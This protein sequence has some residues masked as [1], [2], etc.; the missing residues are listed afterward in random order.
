M[1]TLV[2]SFPLMVGFISILRMPPVKS[3]I[4][5]V[6][7][8]GYADPEK[9]TLQKISAE[10]A[11]RT[12]NDMEHQIIHYYEVSNFGPFDVGN[13]IVNVSWPLQTEDGN[14]LLYMTD[15]PYIKVLK[16]Y[17]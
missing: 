10:K 9:T 12:L 7:V 5:P 1:A 2:T 11:I 16:L 15:V 14:W 8:R 17:I 6:S 3:I 4:S 13:V